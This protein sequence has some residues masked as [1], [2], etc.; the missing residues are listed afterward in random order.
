MRGD[1]GPAPNLKL[2]VQTCAG[3]ET[4]KRLTSVYIW[5]FSTAR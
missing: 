4:G 1:I 3:R 5:L 2:E